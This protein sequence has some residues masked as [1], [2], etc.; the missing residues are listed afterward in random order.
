MTAAKEVGSSGLSE[1]AKI[2][3]L[4]INVFFF[5]LPIAFPLFLYLIF[6]NLA[7]RLSAS[8]N[9]F[10]LKYSH[11]IVAGLLVIF[12]IFLLWRGG[13]YFYQ[14]KYSANQPSSTST[15]NTTT[16][17]PSNST[18]SQPQT[19]NNQQLTTIFALPV[20]NYK[21]GQTKKHFGQYI[22]PATSPVQPERFTG[23]HTG[24]DIEQVQDNTDVSV[25]A[26][27]DGTVRFVSTVSGY[28]GVIVIQFSYQNQTYT[29]LYGHLRIASATVKN[30]D[31]VT[32]GEKLAVLGAPYSSETDGERKH[33]HFAIHKGSSVVLLGYVQ[34]QS[35]LSSW[36]DPNMII[37]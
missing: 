4:V 7:G 2:I 19:T 14:K 29:A 22:T 15:S 30:G 11:Y 18:N 8:I 20:G 23:Y 37:N 10:I 34:N 5:S 26:V 9:H 13:M 32:K 31:K 27:S 21:T 35:E 16:Q 25:Y 28:G 17:S 33:L 36:I 24:V 6:P 12:G 3:L 1:I